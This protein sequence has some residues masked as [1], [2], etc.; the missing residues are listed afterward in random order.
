MKDILKLRALSKS[1]SRKEAGSLPKPWSG[2]PNLTAF[3]LIE[4]L[5]VIAIIAIL[6]GM[7]LPALARARGKA[8][9]TQCI[10]NNKQM[11]LS[12]VMWADENNDGK[13]PWNDGPG[14]VGPDPLRNNWIEL[15][16]YLRNPTVLTCPS[17]KKRIPIQDWAQLNPAWDFRLSLSYMFCVDALPIRP[18]AILTGD[19]FLSSDYPANKTLALPDNAAGGSRH[20]FN[21]PTLIL[22]GWMKDSRH[23]DQGVLSFCDGSVRSTK[24]LQLQQQMRIMF[25]SYLPGPADT[26]KFMLPQYT[27]VPY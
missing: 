20:S 3:T 12:F 16:T 24:P 13:Y 11:V 22:R 9:T 10:N 6:A 17:D 19:N 25:D 7:L 14:K 1:N 15:K 18:Q 26:L 2:Q 4:L 5:V 23:Q 21:R 27:A 8:Q